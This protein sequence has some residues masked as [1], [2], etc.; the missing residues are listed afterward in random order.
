MEQT[1]L[2]G[3]RLHSVGSQ[4]NAVAEVPATRGLGHRQHGVL[5]IRVYGLPHPSEG[6]PGEEA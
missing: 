6:G 5:G 4:G 3:S 2:P 1:D